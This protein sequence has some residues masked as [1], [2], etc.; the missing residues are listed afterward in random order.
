M[1]LTPFVSLGQVSSLCWV[2]PSRG[3]MWSPLFHPGNQTQLL[4]LLPFSSSTA[5]L[6]PESCPP[7]FPFCLLS[8]SPQPV[9]IVLWPPPCPCR[10]SCQGTAVLARAAWFW[11]SDTYSWYFSSLRNHLPIP[12]QVWMWQCPGPELING[13]WELNSDLLQEQQVLLISEPS[14]YPQGSCLTSVVL[15]GMFDL[16]VLNWGPCRVEVSMD[17]QLRPCLIDSVSNEFHC[18]LSSPL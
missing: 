6:F 1:L 13:S 8:F 9:L 11:H 10:P 14:F 18:H 5:S 15:E 12:P 4:A 3:Q 16:S 17:C 2:T 7:P